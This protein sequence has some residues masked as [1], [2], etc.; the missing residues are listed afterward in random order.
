MWTEILQWILQEDLSNNNIELIQ[1]LH[2]FDMEDKMTK[3]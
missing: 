3:I 1:L 2:H